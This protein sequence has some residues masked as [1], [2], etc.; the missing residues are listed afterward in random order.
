VNG[1]CIED[2]RDCKD[3]GTV[4]AAE[5]SRTSVARIAVVMQ[6]AALARTAK[7]RTKRKYMT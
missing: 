2:G 6:I 5:V 4:E 3:G 1:R 7:G